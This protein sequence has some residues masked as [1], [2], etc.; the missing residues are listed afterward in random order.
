MEISDT[1]FIRLWKEIKEALLRIA[2]N[3]SSAKKDEWEN[4]IDDLLRNPLTP[5]EERCIKELEIWYKQDL[6]VRDELQDIR[7]EVAKLREELSSQKF[8]ILGQ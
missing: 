6:H 3:I 7:D 4:S 2:T 5:D 8:A 1:E